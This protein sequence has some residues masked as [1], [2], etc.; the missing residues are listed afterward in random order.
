MGSSQ[1]QDGHDFPNGSHCHTLATC[2][3]VDTERQPSTIE[4]ET[5]AVDGYVGFVFRRHGLLW[6]SAECIPPLNGG[7]IL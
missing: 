1:V 7:Q 6:K 4:T 2:Q 5:D 3:Y